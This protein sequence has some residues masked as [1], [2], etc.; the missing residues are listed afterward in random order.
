MLRVVRLAILVSLLLCIVTSPGT[1]V[2]AESKLNRAVTYLLKIAYNQDL[3][4][5]REA[6]RVAPNVYWIAS[7]NLLAYKALEPYDSKLSSMISS[8]L[9]RL[10]KVYNL[11]TSRGG[12][13][14]SL[15]YDV[16]M[17]DNETLDMPPRNV[18]HLTLYN[19]SYELRYDIANGAG[20][21][22]DWRDYGDLLLL[23]A[24]SDYNRGDNFDAIGNF[25]AAAK[26]WDG[27]GL[28]DNASTTPYGEG[29][30]QGYPYAYATYKLGLLLYVSGRLGRHLPFESDV[31]NRIW[32]M[33]D[34]TNGGIFTHIT[35]G[36]GS[37]G[38]DT[39]TETTALVILG[40]TSIRHPVPEFDIV[41]FILIICLSVAVSVIVARRIRQQKLSE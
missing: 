24:L 17:R 29:Q 8:E 7:D 30:A 38:S 1:V 31:V 15:R 26:M 40:I 34:P 14:L 25:T 13:P 36:G 28:R 16:M 19:G 4:L 20:T 27:T 35:P 18:T 33:Q 5:C 37:G 9:V 32:S 2:S 23:V 21:F 41:T 3:H 12:I 10:A 11:P 6:P 22:N 39:N